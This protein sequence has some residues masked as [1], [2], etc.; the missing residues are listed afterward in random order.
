MSIRKPESNLNSMLHPS[1]E[2]W[3]ICSKINQPVISSLDG[4]VVCEKPWLG[5][6]LDK[7]DNRPLSSYV[8]LARPSEI[9]ILMLLRSC[10]RRFGTFPKVLY[11]DDRELRGSQLDA[12][13]AYL[14][15]VLAWPSPY[16]PILPGGRIEHFLADLV[17]DRL[18]SSH[19]CSA[20][21]KPLLLTEVRQLI[22]AGL[23]RYANWTLEVRESFKEE[24]QSGNTFQQFIYNP[25]VEILTLP[26]TPGKTI[27]I[28]QPCD[29]MINSLRY[30]HPK[31]AAPSVVGTRV[32]VR[33]HPEDISVA[34]AFVNKKWIQLT[35][36]NAP[37]IICSV[38]EFQQ[39]MKKYRPSERVLFAS[40]ATL[41]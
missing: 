1:E 25:V 31:L 18:G 30:S 41:N 20:K 8:S 34:Y 36:K 28:S 40:S 21:T 38:I 9:Y 26:S 16:H 19:D 2:S 11:I 14:S 12:A 24:S 3:I 7:R 17:G 15:L 37:P 5:V 4:E 27:P 23:Q 35:G 6:L 29:I 33:Y 22:E 10:V 13:A 39:F 32:P